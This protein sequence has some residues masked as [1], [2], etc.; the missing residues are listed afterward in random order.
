MS[1]P[2]PIVITP[3][4]TL[5]IDRKSCA[6][7]LREVSSMST[8]CVRELT[9]VPALFTPIVPAC[10]TPSSMQSMPPHSRMRCS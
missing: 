8:R 10:P 7:S 6:D 2:R 9:D 4:G 3:A 5:S 1:V